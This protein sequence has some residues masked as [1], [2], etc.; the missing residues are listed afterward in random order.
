MN[1]KGFNAKY[2]NSLCTSER[3]NIMS[4]L[5]RYHQIYE[6]DPQELNLLNDI[7]VS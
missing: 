5:I 6:H 1:E 4:H 7:Q 2:R 3:N